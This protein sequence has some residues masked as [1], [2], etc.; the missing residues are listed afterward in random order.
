MI[1]IR[2]KVM[3]IHPPLADHCLDCD[4][5]HAVHN[6]LSTN[7]KHL[8]REGGIKEAHNCRRILSR[9]C[10]GLFRMSTDSLGA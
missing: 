2:M 1:R 8:E 5:E 3:Q 10:F 4:K 7:K 9:D 6:G